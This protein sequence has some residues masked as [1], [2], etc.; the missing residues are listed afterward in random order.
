MKKTTLKVLISFVIFSTLFFLLILPSCGGGEDTRSSNTNTSNTTKPKELAL[1]KAPE[2]NVDSAYYF[3]QKQVSFGP[4]VPNSQGHK[5]C[6][7]YLISQLKQYGW[8]VQVQEFT[9]TAYDGTLLSS[10]NIIA[11]FN[12]GEPTRILLA[13]HWDTRHV[14]D[15]DSTDTENP[16]DGANDGASGVG[17]LMEVARAISSATQKPTYGVDII[18]F[19][20]EDYGPPENSDE[21]QSDNSFWCLGSQHWSKNKVPENYT[22]Y[23][24][25][26]LDMVGAKD[27]VFYQEGHSIQY[28]GNVT[29][30]VW[31][32]ANKIGHSNQFV[33][34]ESPAIIDDHYFVNKEAGIPMIDIIEYDVH[35]ENAYFASY[36]HTHADNM[37]IIDRNTL[38]AVGKTVLQVIYSD[39]KAL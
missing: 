17:V 22:A 1:Q 25:I 16:I 13:A 10:R 18:F 20:S 11:S 12:S 39:I 5:E 33:N 24:G 19:D 32:V 29:R 3:V 7:D 15:K 27:A 2:F 9:A 36:H 23:F 37:D 21:Y 30:Y 28:A 6:G 35:R 31:N 8:E 4:R 26:L 34:K 38:N 14:A